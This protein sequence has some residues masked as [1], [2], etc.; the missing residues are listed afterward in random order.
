MAN[1]LNDPMGQ[2]II[3]Y[4]Q[5]GKAEDIQVISDICDDDVIPVSYLFRTYDEMPEMEQ[6]ALKNCS[7]RVLDIGAA[8]GMHAQYLKEKGL[9]VDVI[10]ISPLS[11]QH[12]K[13]SNIE[14]TKIDFFDY[15]GIAYDTLLFLMNGIGIAKNLDNLEQTLLKAKGM[16]N[17]N[18]KILCDSSDIKYL[19]EDDEGGMW[20][21]LNTTYYG[22]FK[23]QMKYGE[24]ESDWFE[25]LYV[26]FEKLKEIAHKVGFKAK[27]LHEE[28]DQYLAELTLS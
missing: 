1:R 23:F 27:I 13:N 5:K 26:D 17:E 8:A 24:H 19:Y 3:D 22:N 9:N 6:I 21:D 2:A 12:L 15:K 18:G 14:A 11:V 25:W 7:G 28:E 20:V 4:A 16:L 10:D